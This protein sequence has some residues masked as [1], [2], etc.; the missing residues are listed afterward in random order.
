MPAILLFW[1]RAERY[2]LPR[3]PRLAERTRLG[4]RRDSSP[5][6]HGGMGAVARPAVSLAAGGMQEL[7]GDIPST[8]A[9]FRCR[10][11]GEDTLRGLRVTVTDEGTRWH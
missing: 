4:T 1:S 3:H 5:G 9:W 7:P 11:F 6:G 2:A 8:A 10:A